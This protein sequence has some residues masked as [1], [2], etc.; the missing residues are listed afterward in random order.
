MSKNLETY[1]VFIN[2]LV[3]IRESVLAKRFKRGVWHPEPPP[4]QVKYNKLLNSLTEEQRFLLAEIIQQS[5]DNAIHDVLV[6]FSDNEYRI[7]K[8]KKPLPEEPF[9]TSLNYDF[10]CR[11]EGDEWPDE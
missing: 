9:D 10:V 6:Y 5:A 1:K 7:Y 3:E 2:G 4:D 11:L 8:N